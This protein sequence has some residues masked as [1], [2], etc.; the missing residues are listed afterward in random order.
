[1]QHV[2]PLR[3]I[4]CK[5]ND[6]FVL[7]RQRAEVR[8]IHRSLQTGPVVPESAAAL[9]QTVRDVDQFR[10]A[11]EYTV[12]IMVTLLASRRNRDGATNVVVAETRSIRCLTLHEIENGHAFAGVVLDTD[13]E[14]YSSG[15][16]PSDDDDEEQPDVEDSQSV[17]PSQATTTDSTPE[18][19]PVRHHQRDQSFTNVADLAWP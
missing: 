14:S 17:P 1:M 12:N 5:A 15:S 16:L 13:T 10:S 3:A 9:V 6:P 18:H 2:F 8:G 11:V 7:S 19:T 4:V